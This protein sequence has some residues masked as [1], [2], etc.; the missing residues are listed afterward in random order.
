MR[1][2]NE[3]GINSALFNLEMRSPELL[4]LHIPNSSNMIQDEILK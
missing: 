1:A 2:D 4:H 3:T